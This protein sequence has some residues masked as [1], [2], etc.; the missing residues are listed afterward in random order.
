MSH[1]RQFSAH[2]H[3]GINFSHPRFTQESITRGVRVENIPRN[4]HYYYYP[5]MPT[6]PHPSMPPHPHHNMPPHLYPRITPHQFCVC[7]YLTS[8][9]MY[10]PYVVPKYPNIPLLCYLDYPPLCLLLIHQKTLVST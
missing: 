5:I 10:V 7:P 2:N 1:T 9:P 3:G 6:H 8:T 4:H